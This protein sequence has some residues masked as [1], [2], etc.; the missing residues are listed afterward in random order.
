MSDRRSVETL[1]TVVDH[2]ILV[3]GVGPFVVLL[4]Q[5]HRGTYVGYCAC[6]RGRDASRF[7]RLPPPGP[8][9]FAAPSVDFRCLYRTHGHGST[10]F[11]VKGRIVR[12]SDLAGQGTRFFPHHM[13]TR[14]LVTMIFFRKVSTIRTIVRYSSRI[15]ATSALAHVRVVILVLQ[16][17]LHKFL[18]SLV[19]SLYFPYI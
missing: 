9:C 17:W 7:Y 16:D 19:C 8:R 18:H 12:G 3:C 2:D 11:T 5:L 15:D 14:T 6:F 10:L 1:L 13:G 4:L